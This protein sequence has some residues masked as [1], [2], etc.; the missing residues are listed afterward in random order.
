MY[1][2]R[3]RGEEV[4]I[5]RFSFLMSNFSSPPSSCQTFQSNFLLGM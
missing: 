5:R 1:V 3:E 4:G 2:G